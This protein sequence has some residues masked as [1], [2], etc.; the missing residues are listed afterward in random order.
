M[1]ILDAMSTSISGIST[2]SYALENISGNIANSSTPGFKR[3]DTGFSDMLGEANAKGRTSTQTTAGSVGAYSEVANTI[4]G[5]IKSTG[6]QTNMALSGGGLFVVAQN[7][8]S[9]TSPSFTGQSLYTRRGDFAQDANGY[10]VNGAG[11]YLSGTTSGPGA[12][13]TN[14]PIKVPK[15]PNAAGSA[16]SNIS[17]SQDG[18]IV[19]NYADGS[20]AKLAQVG[21]AHF[22]AADGLSREDGGAYSATS[23]T[24]SP[25]LGLNGTTITGGSIEASNT[26]ISDQFSKMIVTQ[27]AYSSNTKVLTTANEMLQTAINVL[28]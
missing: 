19:G 20:T 10:L 5:A 17:I 11:Y 23:A 8:G 6:V 22:G 9:A 3:V 26:D 25:T 18:N 12:A 1:S 4:Q 13:T 24:G 14:G 16:L 21:I 15:A 2:Q 7:D 28:R 27:Q